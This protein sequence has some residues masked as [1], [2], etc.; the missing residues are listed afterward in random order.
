VV[1][2]LE[3]SAVT[4]AALPGVIRAIHAAL[5]DLQSDRTNGTSETARLLQT[6]PSPRAAAQF[7]KS[8]FADHLV[9][10]EDGKHVTMLKRHLTTAHSLT[11]ELYRTKWSLPSNYP[12]VA[13]N[14]AKIRSRLAKETGL[15]KG[16]RPGK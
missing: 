3:A 9:C 2:W 7:R 15:G 10:S 6:R 13:P 12:M 1:A 8:V 16:G 4:P 11:P 14:Y 5:T